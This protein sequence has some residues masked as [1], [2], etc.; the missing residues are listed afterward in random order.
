MKHTARSNLPWECHRAT[1]S[2][3]VVLMGAHTS[4]VARKII[5]AARIGSTSKAARMAALQ[6]ALW[7]GSPRAARSTANRMACSRA[8][9]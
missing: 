4:S 7:A 6:A 3:T 1:K 5:S 8:M 9:I 2:Q